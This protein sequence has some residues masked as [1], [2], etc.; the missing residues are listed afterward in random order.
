MKPRQCAGC[1]APLPTSDPGEQVRCT[2]CGMVHD[3]TTSLAD[4]VTAAN[5]AALPRVRVTM[6]GAGLAFLVF[7]L[8][9]L[10]PVG[11]MLYSAVRS[12]ESLVR[13]AASAVSGTPARLSIKAVTLDELG[14]LSPGYHVLD[15]TPPVTGFAAFDPV[16][17]LPWALAVAQ[18]WGKDVRLERIDVERVHP[19]GLLNVADDAEA[20]VTYRFVS[21][22]KI[23]E[24]RRRADLSSTATVQTEFWL[25]VKK[26][27]MT[28]F[29]PSTPGALL[30]LREHEG[31]PPEHP[32]KALPLSALFTKLVS[33][34]E[35]RA[36]FYQGY[37]IHVEDE[38]WVW[39]FSTF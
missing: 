24:L 16:V 26:G 32:A 8:A 37:L 34:P 15:A 7:M 3:P 11:L 29:S 12:G 27:E 6:P 20:E 13:T 39:Y 18:R 31:L 5:Q 10:V 33:R 17:Q 2:F 23:A 36:P 22:D 25:K 19:D 28:V 21:P 1:G 38:G 4:I 30:V 35:Y 14:D 9:I